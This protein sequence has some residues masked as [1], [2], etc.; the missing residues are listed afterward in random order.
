[1]NLT[2]D[3]A[4]R[5][6]LGKKST[7][8]INLITWISIVGISI[9]T[10]ALLLILSVFNGFE[11]LLSGLFNSYNPDLKVLPIEGRYIEV[12]TIALHQIANL[13]D[14]LAMSRTIEEVALFEYKENQEAGYIK[15]VDANFTKVTDIDSIMVNGDF[16]IFGPGVNYCVLGSGMYNKLNVNPADPLSSVTVYMPSVGKKGPLDKDY[17]ARQTYPRGVFS[18]GNED[19]SQYILAS[20]PFVNELLNG[21]NLISS[22][23]IRLKPGAPEASVRQNILTI[24]GDNVKIKNRYE[25]DEAF[26]KIMNIEKWV[27]YLIASLTLGIIAFNLIGSLWMIVLE[28]KKDISILR[29]MGMNGKDVGAIFIGVGLLVGLIGLTIGIL[30]ALVAYVLQKYFDLISIPSGFMIDSYPIALKM[31]DFV[32]V[33]VTVMVITFL[34]SVLPAYRASQISAYVRQE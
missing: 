15:G 14:I 2:L 17:I 8:A 4:R 34:A 12:D 9:G 13:Q 20:Y 31:G 3:I 25:Q 10:A 28:K 33:T 1:M 30:V 5:Y 32:I 19:D 23:E 18:A 6:L 21:E 16:G 26:L 7:N 24:L 29:S 11:S 22:L 27:S